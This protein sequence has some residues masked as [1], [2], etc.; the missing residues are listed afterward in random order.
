MNNNNGEN[1][2]NANETLAYTQIPRKIVLYAKTRIVHKDEQ[3]DYF[4]PI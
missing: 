1:E 3:N 2:L 4:V